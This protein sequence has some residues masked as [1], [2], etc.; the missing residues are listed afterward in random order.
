MNVVK[1]PENGAS[2]V[3][4]ST[5]GTKIT[6]G[7]DEISANLAKKERDDAVRIDVCKDYLDELTFGA[8]GARVY[9]AEISIPARQYQ[10][11]QIENP[12]YD[13]ENPDSQQYITERQPVPF[14]MDNVTLTLFEE[15]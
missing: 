5:R 14:S 2:F 1:V 15:V 10:D 8:T 13:P 6:F 11:T 4:Y 9:V 3:E 7:D 12:D